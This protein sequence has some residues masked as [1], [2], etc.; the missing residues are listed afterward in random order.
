MFPW[1]APDGSVFPCEE[2]Q[3]E[4]TPR[5]L[6]VCIHGLGGAAG[7]FA[8]LAEAVVSSGCAAY[9]L[10]LR[11]QG[12]DPSPLRRG[13]FLELPEVGR[14][15]A[16]FVRHA[17]ELVPGVPLFLCGESMGALLVSW[18]LAEKLL[19]PDEING[20]ILSVPVVALRRPTPPPLRAIMRALAAFIPRAHIKHSWFVS[21][22]KT[23]LKI[24]RDEAYQRSLSSKPHH[25][26]S[27]SIG[28]LNALGNLMESS[29]SL[30][31][32]ITVPC[33]VLVAGCDIYIRPEQTS[34]WFEL[35]SASDK[36]LKIYPEAYHILWH[37]WDKALVLGDIMGWLDERIPP[38]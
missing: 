9:S 19:M 35:I 4:T 18:L 37:D 21:R 22:K 36:T 33:L 14:D 16:A 15:I 24:T 38:A 31:P 26:P 20:V 27:F 10:N 7:D 29:S 28:F 34:A 12:L 25:V 23:P 11:G 2:W 17:R 30:A 13:H 5:A 32:K 8:P 1:T 3:P 6:V